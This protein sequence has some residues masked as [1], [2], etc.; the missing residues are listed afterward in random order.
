MAFRASTCGHLSIAPPLNAAE[1]DYISA[2]VYTRRHAGRDH[3]YDVPDNPAVDSVIQIG[4]SGLPESGNLAGNVATRDIDTYHRPLDGQPSLWCPWVPSCQ[5]K[6]LSLEAEEKISAPVTWLQYLIDHFLA[7]EAQARGSGRLEF[8]H[9]TFDHS[10]A[11]GVALH[12]SES[13][14]LSLIHVVGFSVV[15]DVLSAGE[16]E[17]YGPSRGWVA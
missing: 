10:I 17:P 4:A 9:F 6:C 11:G 13:N 12:S 3:P 5:G 1:H 14:E 15:E 8:A 2:F 16:P 7:P